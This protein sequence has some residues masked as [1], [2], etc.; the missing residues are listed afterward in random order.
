MSVSSPPGHVWPQ[1]KSWD[2]HYNSIAL[3]HSTSNQVLPFMSNLPPVSY[4][5]T[6]SIQVKSH[7]EQVQGLVSH[8]TSTEAP[9]FL[10]H[11]HPGT[12]MSVSTP[13]R[14]HFTSSQAPWIPIYPNPCPEICISTP[15]K[16]V[17]SPARSWYTSLTSR[18]LYK[19]ST[20]SRSC[21]TFTTNQRLAFQPHSVPTWLPSRSQYLHAT[22]IHVP[23]WAF[24]T[25]V[26][27]HLHPGR[28]TLF[29]S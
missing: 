28:E 22:S 13:F 16:W 10:S 6:Q 11:F 4:L 7:L 20:P 12:Y 25:L 21:I 2:F 1:S 5:V 17:T 29:L 3:A 24:P 27:S 18:S 8:L 19:F 26:T 9:I 15:S 23:I 14:S